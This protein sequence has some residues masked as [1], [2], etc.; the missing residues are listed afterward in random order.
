MADRP[1]Y[2]DTGDD[3]GV[4]LERETTTT[5][6][7]RWVKVLGTIVAVLVL[8]FVI[9]LFTGGGHRPGRHTLVGDAGSQ[10]PPS[11]VTEDHAPPEGGDG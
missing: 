7:P 8:V 2:P 5:G 4:G 6:T 3:T 10:A 9:A 11:S 1:R